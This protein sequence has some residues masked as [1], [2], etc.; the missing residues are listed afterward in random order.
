ML[1]TTSY[2]M[3]KESLRV[4]A[5][6]WHYRILAWI[7]AQWEMSLAP[8]IP[9]VV[10][11]VSQSVK[12]SSRHFQMLILVVV[13]VSLQVIPMNIKL[14]QLRKRRLLSSLASQVLY[15]L[16]SRKSKVSLLTHRPNLMR[17]KQ[18]ARKP[19]QITAMLNTKVWK[20]QGPSYPPLVREIF[21]P[22]LIE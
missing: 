2:R 6:E 3:M 13:D 15:H 11:R 7:R 16:K 4:K 21:L 1:T 20:P 12:S 14:S 9:Q 19:R 8:K 22:I 18:L 5:I 10:R 17:A